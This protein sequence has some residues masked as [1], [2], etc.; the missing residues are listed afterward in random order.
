MERTGLVAGDRLVVSTDGTR[1]VLERESDPLEQ[2]IG[3]MPDV[4]K[5]FDLDA[6]R[7]EWS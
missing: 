3:S 1:V 7:D 2:F 6:S 4:W 5:G